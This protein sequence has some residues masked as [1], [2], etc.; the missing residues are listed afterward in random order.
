MHYEIVDLP[1]D[2]KFFG[3]TSAKLILKNDILNYEW[4]N[5]LESVS[6]Y[7]FVVIQNLN[8]NYN[9]S[10]Y[11]GTS[12]NAFLTDINI[13]FQKKID[14][15]ST[16]DEYEIAEKTETVKE[17]I[18]SLTT[19]NHSRFFNDKDLYN[20]GGANIYKEWVINSFNN[21]DKKYIINK[22][23]GCINGYALI[24]ES[25]EEIIIELIS[26]DSNQKNK[27]I[28]RKLFNSIVNYGIEHKKS[29]I[30]VGTQI[31]NTQAINFYHK[32]GCRQTETHQ[33]F[34]FWKD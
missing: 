20:N 33:I 13:Q 11:L 30:N 27:G 15:L 29:L 12:T 34:H 21:I 32:M 18:L 7:E 16:Y 10:K 3:Y 26:V 17:S 22:E 8:S 24:S 23:N 4:D 31:T 2:T 5:I 28:G 9:N 14:T 1:W 6:G 25:R 19:F